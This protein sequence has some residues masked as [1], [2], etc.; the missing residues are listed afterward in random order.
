MGMI[1]AS[2]ESEM[3]R[4]VGP[5]GEAL[6]AR[7]PLRVGLIATKFMTRWR[8]AVIVDVS[9]TTDCVL[10]L[11]ILVQSDGPG[12]AAGRRSW[13]GRLYGWVD[14]CLFRK[15]PDALDEV[16][17]EDL[18]R[19]HPSLDIRL[20][21]GDESIEELDV[22]R[23]L[24]FELDVLLCLGPEPQGIRVARL[25]RFGTWAYRFGELGESVV[26]PVGFREVLGCRPSATV[27]LNLLGAGPA[28]EERVLYSTRLK[29]NR[30]SARRHGDHLG[31]VASTLVGRVLRQV[32]EEESLDPWTGLGA[33][34]GRVHPVPDN[35]EMTR[36]LVSFV[37]RIAAEGSH[38]LIYRDQWALGYSTVG[39]WEGHLPDLRSLRLIMPPRDRFWADPFPI[40]IGGRTHVFF[41]DYYYPNRKAH[42]SVFEIDDRGR[43]GVPKLALERPYHLSYPFVFSWGGQLYMIPETTASGNVELYRCTGI[44]DRWEFDRMLLEGVRAADVTL[45][46]HDG[47]WWLF[48][49]IPVN[50]AHNDFEELHLFH[51]ECPL[52]PWS[53]HRRNPVKSDVGSSRPAGRLY[54]REGI[55]YRPA[56][57]CA[58]GYG[59]SI[60]LNRV[61]VWNR[62]IYKEVPVG[63]LDSDWAPGLDRTHTFNA[64]GSLFV[65]DVRVSRLRL[66]RGKP[67]PPMDFRD[68]A[69]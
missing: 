68:L 49:N 61:E 62:R 38:R 46:E 18:I 24:A 58:L 63:R 6:Q 19:D 31:A 9:A 15:G 36:L 55:W 4:Q 20:A 33:P 12:P 30:I 11:V 67:S 8:R 26:E 66:G 29:T 16:D 28:R 21:A 2:G 27:S 39:E 59:Y 51:A 60:V 69:R 17:V 54:Q 44:P 64:L 41:E 10:A 48:G 53:P 47:L 13:I 50:G 32:Q 14:R 42:I 43:V 56:Q 22:D 45:E 34:G 23:I 7:R 35:A 5:G 25:A 57:D 37:G 40:Q 3:N 52:G 1:Q 65:V